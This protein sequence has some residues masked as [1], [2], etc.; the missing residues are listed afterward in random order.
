MR[1]R[2]MQL[3]LPAPMSLVPHILKVVAD[4]HT[5]DCEDNAA[6]CR[7]FLTNDGVLVHGI[8][9]EVDPPQATPIADRIVT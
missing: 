1:R 4:W 3:G 9:T 2:I 8:P 6:G 7:V 5:H